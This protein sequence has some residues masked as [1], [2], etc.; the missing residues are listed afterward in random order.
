MARRDR[1]KVE[2]PDFT[3]ADLAAADEAWDRPDGRGRAS[4]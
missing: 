3:D 1:P 2:R 4:S